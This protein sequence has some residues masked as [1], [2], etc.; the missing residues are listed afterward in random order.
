MKKNTKIFVAPMIALAISGMSVLPTPAQAGLVGGNVEYYL[1]G[2]TLD[3]VPPPG[4][5][6]IGSNSTIEFT[7]GPRGTGDMWVGVAFRDNSPTQGSI[8]F[9]FSGS[10][11]PG[12]APFSLTLSNFQPTGG[13]TIQNIAGSSFS[14]PA[15]T[16]G[17]TS[18][19]GSQAVFTGLPQNGYFQALGGW[20]T[21]FDVT[22][23]SPA[24]YSNVP[25]P[26]SAALLGAGLL[27][28]GLV[29]RR[30]ARRESLNGQQA[31]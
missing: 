15:G 2:S 17:L 10:T 21:S 19:T 7:V 11:L 6:T 25:E 5:A 16:F 27:G 4:V 12:A 14:L 18:W 3:I 13:A 30:A 23:A 1:R 9:G 22:L 28:L 31:A 29:R 8:I 26:M 24:P 20:W